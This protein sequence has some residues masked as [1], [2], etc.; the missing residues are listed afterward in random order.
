MASASLAK[1]SELL[2]HQLYECN[3]QQIPLQKEI[4]YLEN[5]IELEKLRHNTQIE[6]DIH[7]EN[8][9]ADEMGIAP[10]ILMTFVENAFKHV[11]AHTGKLN[12]INIKLTQYQQ[13]LELVIANSTSAVIANEVIQYGG[14]GLNNVKRRLDLLYPGAYELDIKNGH[15]QFEIRLIL[16]LEV[17]QFSPAIQMTAI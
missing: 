13:Q 9:Y 8:I 1:F 12:W 7:L 2:R 14:I 17:L 15:Q 16:S 4:S 10:F 5:Y 6:T 3:D 11:S